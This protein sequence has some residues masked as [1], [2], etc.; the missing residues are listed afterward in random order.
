MKSKAT[1]D[2][3][4]TPTQRRS[5]QTVDAILEAVLRILKQSGPDAVT[6]NR[7][8]EIAGVSIGSVYQ[9]FPDKRAIF[10][11]LHQRHVDEIDH[12]I[13]S[14]I[15]EHESSP[16][17][18]AVRAIIER[19]IDAHTND[20][21]LYEVLM[22]AVPHRAGG[23]PEFSVRLHATFRLALSARRHEVKKH[24]DPDKMA[25][26][27]ANMVES[28]SHGSVLRRPQGISLATA[29]EEAIQA[30]LAYLRL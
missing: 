13:R 30:V 26:V 25:F 18:V 9:Y 22:M 16:L 20:P 14:T 17:E 4:R 11:A 7:I 2:V 21:R 3:R 29:K 12:L 19:M 6:T 27:V 10:A 28:L 5:R 23:A 1:T 15:V 8:A 24:R